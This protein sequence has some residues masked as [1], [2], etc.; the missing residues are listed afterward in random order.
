MNSRPTLLLT[1]RWPD[2]VER[3]LS[4]RY[5][6]TLNQDDRELTKDALCDAMRRFDVLCPTVTD[7]IDSQVINASG[8][9]VRL[10]ANYG[11]G[12]DHIDL[13]AARAA[14]LPVTNTPDVL[15]E[16]T[17][18]L[19]LLLMLMVSRRA[20]Q[21]E[22]DVRAG[23]WAGWAPTHCLGQDIAG[24]RLGIVGFGRIGQATAALAKRTLRMHISY[25]SRG[26]A[27]KETEAAFGAE[28]APSLGELVADVDV[29]S[30]HCSGGAATYH[31]VDAALLKRMR[32]RAILINTARGSVVNEADLATALQQGWLFGAGLDVFENEPR[33]NSALLNLDNAV[34]LPH[35]GS[36][37]ALTRHAM[38]MRVVANVDRFFSGE[39]LID[40][41]V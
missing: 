41:V 22:R 10:I 5:R 25:Y 2:D 35:L 7:S 9:K 13:D 27:S 30:I 31:L 38:G 34:L 11:A 16:A 17:A 39:P 19:A 33:V 18:E 40:R 23:R 32:R 24:K 6:V 20:G 8:A 15:A 21:G 29:L 28:Y 3:E 12:V 26:R 14:L 1:R 4:A 37:T 36:A